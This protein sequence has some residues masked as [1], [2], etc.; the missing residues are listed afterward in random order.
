M[1]PGW[2][3]RDVTRARAV[4]QFPIKP[5]LPS[6]GIKLQVWLVYQIEVPM[7]TTN[8]HKNQG[9]GVFC[10]LWEAFMLR[11]NTRASARAASN[12]IT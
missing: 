12:T 11:C 4:P 1:A 7:G 5:L 2:L 3:S 10:F 9:S 8:W 6:R